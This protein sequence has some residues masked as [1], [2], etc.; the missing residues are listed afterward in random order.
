MTGLWKISHRWII[1]YDLNIILAFVA[2]SP[3]LWIC[4]IYDAKSVI[5]TKFQS[6]SVLML[7]FVTVTETSALLYHSVEYNCC[8]TCL[9]L[10]LTKILFTKFCTTEWNLHNF[11]NLVNFNYLIINNYGNRRNYSENPTKYFRLGR[12]EITF[13]IQR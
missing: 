1:L 8:S 7:F 13:K 3:S 12:Y 2:L 6:P 5:F 10:W 9:W 11:G 4:G